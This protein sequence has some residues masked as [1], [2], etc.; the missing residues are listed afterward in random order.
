[1]ICSECYDYF[2]LPDDRS[3]G[4]N[5][6]NIIK[7][8][9]TGWRSSGSQGTCGLAANSIGFNS[10]TIVMI[11]NVQLNVDSNVFN[12]SLAEGVEKRRIEGRQG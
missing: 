6:I 1:M 2:H 12:R 10:Q 4:G 5:S 3:T 9:S 7:Q 8:I 11:L